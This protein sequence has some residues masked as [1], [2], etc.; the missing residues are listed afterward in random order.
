[1]SE[2]EH[3]ERRDKLQV[4]LDAA[5][6][7]FLA[8]GFS[9]A[10]TDMIQRK[11]H[12]SKATLYA[13]FPN[14][15]ALFAAVIDAQCAV[16]ADK[17]KENKVVSNNIE[18]TL[19]D[20]GLSYLRLILS[21]NVLALFRVAV[22]EAPRFPEL[23]RTFYLAGPKVTAAMVLEK[24]KIAAE[25]GEIDVQAVGLD[26]AASLFLALLRGEGHME[27][28]THPE[29]QPSEEQLDK[30]VRY[31]VITFLKAFG[32]SSDKG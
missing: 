24:L 19:T 3:M 26:V 30:W 2:S 6:S 10:T 27:C 9:A 18:E 21:P 4:I 16:M 8:Y 31:A 17:M 7:V 32:K 1:M 12:I 25:M 11:A 22:A 5:S 29:S 23:G 20:I 13:C 15:E 28:L 14:K